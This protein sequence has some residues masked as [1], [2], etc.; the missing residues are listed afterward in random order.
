MLALAVSNLTSLVIFT[1]YSALLV[2]ILATLQTNLPFRSFK[3][4]QKL[5]DWKLGVLQSS[6]MFDI[7]SMAPEGSTKN[8]VCKQNVLKYSKTA[9]VTTHRAGLENVFKEPKNAYF[10]VKETVQYMLSNQ[11]P[12][13]YKHNIV[14]TGLDFHVYGLT[15]GIQKNSPF[16]NI[17]NYYI[18]KMITSGQMHH[19]NSKWWPKE[20]DITEAG[21][22]SPSLKEVFTL[23]LILLIGLV[24]SIFFFTLEQFT[25]KLMSRT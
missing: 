23:F 9:I 11:F 5:P 21:Y 2:S 13:E 24:A 6:A 20:E 22:P 1:R 10:G 7:L 18:I 19:L 16:Y 14:D 4:L 15:M 25:K 17:I 8:I 3:D 12:P